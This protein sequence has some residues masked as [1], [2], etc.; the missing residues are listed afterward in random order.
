M[1]CARTVILEVPSKQVVIHIRSVFKTWLFDEG[2]QMKRAER[3]A[4]NKYVSASSIVSDWTQALRIAQN[5]AK[6]A[7]SGKKNS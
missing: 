2:Y 1:A 6:I 4:N 3:L 5:T 7:A